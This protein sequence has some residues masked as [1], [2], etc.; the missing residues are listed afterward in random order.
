M[1][2]RQAD[3]IT[4]SGTLADGEQVCLSGFGFLADAEATLEFDGTP[5]NGKLAIWDNTAGV[6]L[7]KVTGTS[8]LETG[9]VESV[10]GE[11]ADLESC[12]TNKSGVNANYSLT[13]NFFSGFP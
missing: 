13:F 11:N 3:F 8:P 6:R 4:A 10:S 12:L 9:T 2:F 5:V 1:T 7:V